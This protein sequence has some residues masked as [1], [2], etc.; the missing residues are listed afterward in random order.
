MKINIST[1]VVA[2]IHLKTK[3]GSDRRNK[4]KIAEES[5]KIFFF[6]GIFIPALKVW[7]CP[8]FLLIYLIVIKK[9]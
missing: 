4:M 7:A 3:E 1:A 5:S 8:D 9:F 2:E 6:L